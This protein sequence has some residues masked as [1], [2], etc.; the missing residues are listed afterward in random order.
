MGQLLHIGLLC[1]LRFEKQ[2]LLVMRGVLS[3]VLILEKKLERILE[4]RQ[5]LKQ[6]SFWV[7]VIIL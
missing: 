1:T 4:K 6:V 3:L 2:S 7:D 5:T